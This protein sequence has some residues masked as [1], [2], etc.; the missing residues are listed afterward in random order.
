MMRCES[1]VARARR[2]VSSMTGKVLAFFSSAR[3]SLVTVTACDKL[4]GD[5]RYAPP[6]AF[7]GH[8]SPALSEKTLSL[9]A[10]GRQCCTSPMLSSS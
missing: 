9:S 5:I 1:A 6:T 2:T 4:S 3:T 7:G 10:L 8:T